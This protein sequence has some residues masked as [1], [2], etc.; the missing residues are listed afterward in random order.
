MFYLGYEL[1]C[2]STEVRVFIGGIAEIS[3]YVKS[4]NMEREKLIQFVENGNI[5][6]K[7][8]QRFGLFSPMTN[9]FPPKI[10]LALS[11]IVINRLFPAHYFL[12][13]F[14]IRFLL[15]RCV[16]TSG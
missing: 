9:A 13:I 1:Y 8:S 12:T 11:N 15:Y 7:S 5:I 6:D 14:D 16:H 10:F 2:T 4:S 3:C